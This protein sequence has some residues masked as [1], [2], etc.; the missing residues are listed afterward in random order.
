[1]VNNLLK[2][3]QFP[4]T[5]REHPAV[6]LLKR[7]LET[8]GNCL[9]F[10]K[11]RQVLLCISQRNNYFSTTLVTF[12]LPAETGANTSTLSPLFCFL[13][14]VLISRLYLLR[15]FLDVQTHC[16]LDV[17]NNVCQCR[18]CSLS[19]VHK[20]VDLSPSLADHPD[21]QLQNMKYFL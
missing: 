4:F 7:N 1:M 20:K 6:D 19:G 5:R 3:L 8:V 9:R 14:K 13:Q 16:F 12:G 21:P 10:L 18:C 15:T 2:S 17:P 11:C